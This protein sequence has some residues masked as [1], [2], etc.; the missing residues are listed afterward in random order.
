[1]AARRAQCEL[2]VAIEIDS[3]AALKQLV[4]ADDGLCTLLPFG[5]VH[6]EVRTGRLR[7]RAIRSP[8]MRA[9]LVA[10]TPLHRPVTKA[11]R[12]LLDLI[13]TEIRRCVASGILRGRID[14]SAFDRSYPVGLDEAE[15]SM[16]RGHSR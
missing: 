16:P 9:V 8:E 14:A 5:A 10:A 13:R 6:Q 1:M 15:T 7:A 12:V 3:V 2:T 11:T 4:E